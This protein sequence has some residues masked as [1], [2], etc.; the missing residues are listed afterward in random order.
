MVLDLCFGTDFMAK[1]R[2]K[3]D[4][5]VEL[6][7]EFISHATCPYFDEVRL[8]KGFSHQGGV[9]RMYAFPSQMKKAN[10]EVVN[11]ARVKITTFISHTT[12]TFETGF[13]RNCENR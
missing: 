13:M 5:S 4:I 1:T 10:A 8:D 6:F 11:D 3:P 9:P 12:N 7:A 2:D